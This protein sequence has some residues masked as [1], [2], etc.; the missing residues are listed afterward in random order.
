MLVAVL[1]I[2]AD[3]LLPWTW[4]LIAT[5]PI[6]IVAWWVVYRSDWF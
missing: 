5:I 1:G 4:A 6:F 3:L 2:I